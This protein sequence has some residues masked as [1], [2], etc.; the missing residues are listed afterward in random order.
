MPKI[1]SPKDLIAG[2]LFFAIGLFGLWL[3]LEYPVGVALRMGP[4]YLPRL[5][6]YGLTLLGAVIAARGFVVT[7]SIDGPFA[8]R[9]LFGITTSLVLFGLFVERLGLVVTTIAVV[10]A[11]GLSW[12]GARWREMLLVAVG[13]AAFATG[14]FAYALRL[15]I[16]V[17]PRL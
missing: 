8:W 12:R 14:L 5:L 13:L 17:W 6:L 2:L 7:D 10:L 9:P 15:P 3:T 1:T 4:G 11:A 16:P